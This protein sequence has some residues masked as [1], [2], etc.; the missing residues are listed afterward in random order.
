MFS[1]WTGLLCLVFAI[2]NMGILGSLVFLS[3]L[4]LAASIGYWGD[5]TAVANGE[6][7]DLVDHHGMF[8]DFKVERC[9]K[10]KEGCVWCQ[11]LVHYDKLHNQIQLVGKKK[12]VKCTKTPRPDCKGVR[13]RRGE[14]DRDQVV[15]ELF[16]QH[17]IS[18]KHNLWSVNSL[19]EAKFIDKYQE[20]DGS[21]HDCHVIKRNK[22]F[23]WKG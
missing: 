7:W 9:V 6:S 11:Y 3:S 22:G 1:L 2:L 14:I 23:N 8:G 15:T 4:A 16:L 21:W 18:I 13:T 10:I 20:K 19:D 17:C 12:G 5:K